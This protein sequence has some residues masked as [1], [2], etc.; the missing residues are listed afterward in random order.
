MLPEEMPLRGGSQPVAQARG[1]AT[2]LE[3]RQRELPKRLAVRRLARRQRRQRHHHH[4]QACGAGVEEMP[5]C[6]L[7]RDIRLSVSSFTTC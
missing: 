2:P 3:E 6:S 5:F 1:G 4:L 7:L